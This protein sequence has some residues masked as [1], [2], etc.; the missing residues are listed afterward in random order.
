MRKQRNHSLELAILPAGDLLDARY[1]DFDPTERSG[2]C[3]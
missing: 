2:S 1:P 3:H